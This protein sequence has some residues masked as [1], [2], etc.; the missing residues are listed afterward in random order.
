M[1]TF[2]TQMVRTDLTKYGEMWHGHFEEQS[3]VA[4]PCLWGSIPKEFETF[5][6]K[7]DY[8]NGGRAFFFIRTVT[9]Q[10]IL[11]PRREDGLVYSFLSS[12]IFFFLY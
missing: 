8:R 11:R 7:I 5:S 1:S 4:I 3:D 12:S 2:F 10:K 6:K 9:V